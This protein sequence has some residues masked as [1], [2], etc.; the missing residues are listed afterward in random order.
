M[1]KKRENINFPLSFNTMSF[2][3]WSNH[4]W[5]YIITMKAQI[6]QEIE[7]EMREELYNELYKKIYNE[8]YEKLR[9][10]IYNELL[11]KILT[12]N[13]LEQSEWELAE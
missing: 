4:N 11:E 10:E 5:S 3:T 9:I 1:D 12:R 13:S 2:A 6:R 7:K 8:L